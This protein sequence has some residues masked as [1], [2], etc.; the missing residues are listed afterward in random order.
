MNEAR[1]GG[2]KEGAGAARD[3]IC[4]ESVQVH[5]SNS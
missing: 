3:K 5:V 1:K 4:L 2:G